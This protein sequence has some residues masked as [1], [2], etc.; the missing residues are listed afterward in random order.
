MTVPLCV[1]LDG[2]LVKSNVLVETLVG[3][4]KHRPYLALAV[5]FWLARGRAH[6]KREAAQ[7]SQIDVARL[8]YD[9]ALL[10]EL[11][12]ERLAGRTLYLATAA[13]E[14]VARRIA[15]HLGLFDGVIASDGRRNLKG[16][17]KARELA[18]RFGEKGFDYVGN[19]RHDIPVWSHARNAIRATRERHSYAVLARALR[20]H[21]WPKNLLVFVPLLTSHRLLEPEALRIGLHAFVAFCLMASA[22]YLANDLID[23]DDDRRHPRKKSRPVAAGALPVEAALGLIPVLVVAAT[24]VALHLTPEFIVLLGA[25]VAANLAYSLGVKRVALV[26][27]FVLA[28]L[29]TVRILAGAAAAAVVVSHW[30]LAFSLFVFLSLAF[31]KR[32][33]EVSS[34]AARSETGVAG[35]GYGAHDGPLARDP[36][37]RGPAAS[38]L[39]LARVAPRVPRR[40]ARGSR[41][42]RLER[43]AELRG[44]RRDARGDLG[45]DGHGVNSRLRRSISVS[46]P[47]F[48]C[49]ST[50]SVSGFGAPA[51]A[52]SSPVRSSAK[53]ARC[54]SG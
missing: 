32:Y 26:D 19:D 51:C 43:L 35:R 5:P 10:A 45:R 17:E 30:L 23:L 44:R 47:F 18:A 52:R 34:V 15:D 49:T 9:E 21:Q 29:Y 7:R 3:A 2:T 37:V 24:I 39:D 4:L 31:A 40:A 22:V 16:E 33:V 25:Y 53:P 27:V 46:A 48:P 12:R 8:P 36:V 14:G 50:R 1:D 28:G 20:L 42:V 6:L 54:A 38:L 41:R 11:R 13:D